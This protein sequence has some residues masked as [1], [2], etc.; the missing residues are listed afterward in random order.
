MDQQCPTTS[1][2][3]CGLATA[4]QALVSLALAA[5]A[6][7]DLA[8]LDLA[9]R[10][11]RMPTLY[12]KVELSAS[13]LCIC[14]QKTSGEKP[15]DFTPLVSAQLTST[16]FSIG[17]EV[18]QFCFTLLFKEGRASARGGFGTIALSSLMLDSP[19]GRM[20]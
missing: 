12:S 3:G 9:S 18:V 19:G 11:D 4:D 10:N 14:V 17:I 13:G 5:L 2:V 8:S 6:S 1:S 16:A 20:N 15:S 7:L